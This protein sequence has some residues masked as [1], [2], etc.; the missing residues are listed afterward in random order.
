M[1][2]FK[3]K[4][5]YRVLHVHE[6]TRNIQKKKCIFVIVGIRKKTGFKFKNYLN[7]RYIHNRR[8]STESLW[9]VMGVI[10]TGKW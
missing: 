10:N 9:D 4:K 2:Y 1:L 8:K 5:Y 6:M 3:V 7:P